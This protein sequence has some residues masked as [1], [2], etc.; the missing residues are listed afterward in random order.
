MADT[1]SLLTAQVMKQ[2]LHGKFFLVTS[3]NVQG[4]HTKKTV[5]YL[6]FELLRTVFIEKSSSPSDIISF[7]NSSLEMELC[8]S[9]R[10]SMTS[11]VLVVM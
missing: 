7:V 4:A 3:E 5:K 8:A 9:P 1:V 11:L 2:W 10:L 6:C